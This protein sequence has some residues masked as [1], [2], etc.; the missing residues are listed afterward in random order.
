MTHTHT[1]SSEEDEA[2]AEADFSGLR[3]PEAMCRFMAASDYCF[4]YS[5]SN[6]EGTHDPTSECFNVELGVPSASDDD[7]NSAPEELRCLDLEQLRELQAKVKQ[8]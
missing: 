7:E 3:D 2:W 1:D 5:N 6:D 4:S 8:D